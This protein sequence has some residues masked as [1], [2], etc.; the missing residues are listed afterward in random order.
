MAE[1]LMDKLI[2]ALSVVVN[3]D[4]NETRNVD[5]TKVNFVIGFLPAATQQQRDQAAAILAAHDPT[6]LTLLNRQ[7]VLTR[8]HASALWGKSPA[9]IYTLMQNQMDAWTSLADARASLRVWLPAMA[10]AIFWLLSDQEA[11]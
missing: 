3:F 10:A 8:L 7:D 6:D 5:G 1:I 4:P 11:P 2:R 9:Q